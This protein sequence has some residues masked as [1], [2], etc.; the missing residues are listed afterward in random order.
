MTKVI[1]GFIILSIIGLI[2]REILK[3]NKAEKQAEE[4]LKELDEVE[5]ALRKADIEED[6]VDAKVTLKSREAEIAKK[7]EALED[8]P[9]KK[10]K[11]STGKAAGTN[12]KASTATIGVMCN[13]TILSQ[14][15]LSGSPEQSGPLLKKN[16][17]LFFIKTSNP[18]KVA[19]AEMTL[20]CHQHVNEE[21][22]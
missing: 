10:A 14:Q 3:M 13:G 18:Q 20:I 11:K 15:N 6:V 17:K 8:K 7:A 1:I 16:S 2:G 12:S 21:L 4:A 5:N 22:I 9:T 19:A